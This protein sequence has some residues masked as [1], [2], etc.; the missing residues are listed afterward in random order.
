MRPRPHR[1]A[2]SLLE[3]E[4]NLGGSKPVFLSP[5]PRFLHPRA[6]GV[7]GTDRHGGQRVS[8]WGNP[9]PERWVS[10]SG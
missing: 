4:P 9:H 2:M 8:G 5:S 10:C 6:L 1:W 7:R 3:L